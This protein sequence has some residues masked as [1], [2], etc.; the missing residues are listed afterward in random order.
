MLVVPTFY[1]S[2]EIARDRAV[3]KFRLRAPRWTPF[4]AFVATLFEALL[5]L[6][7]V[8]LLFRQSMKLWRLAI[9]FCSISMVSS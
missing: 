1:D 8:R 7:F 3:A 4:G 5:T 9:S 6:L 2:I